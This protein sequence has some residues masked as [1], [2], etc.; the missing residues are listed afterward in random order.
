LKKYFTVWSCSGNIIFIARIQLTYYFCIAGTQLTYYLFIPGTQLTTFKMNKNYRGPNLSSPQ[1]IILYYICIIKFLFNNISLNLLVF[2]FFNLIS[3]KQFCKNYYI[4]KVTTV[5]CLM[6]IKN[7]VW[8]YTPK[9][10]S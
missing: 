1:N 9:Y 4:I 6:N 10:F 7:A 2:F 5:S 3:V 8:K